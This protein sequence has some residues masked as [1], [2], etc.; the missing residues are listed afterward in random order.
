MS[1]EKFSLPKPEFIS[2]EID[3]PEMI[4]RDFRE[5]MLIL[6]LSAILALVFVAGLF[7]LFYFI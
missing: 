2:G 1:T 3:Y 7:T 4:K 6:G 5:A